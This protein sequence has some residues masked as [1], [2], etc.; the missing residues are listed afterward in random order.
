MHS[1]V[2]CTELMTAELWTHSQPHLPPCVDQSTAGTAP[3]IGVDHCVAEDR[4]ILPL[5]SLG[6]LCLFKGLLRLQCLFGSN[7]GGL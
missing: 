6:I 1:A 2:L 4:H 7:G 5:C 3:L